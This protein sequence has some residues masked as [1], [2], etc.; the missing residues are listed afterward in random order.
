MMGFT[1]RDEPE[2]HLEPGE[3]ARH[4]RGTSPPE[5]RVRI[6]AHLAVCDRCTEEFI[7]VWRYSGKRRF[8]PALL[9]LGVAA[10][11]AVAALLL[12]PPARRPS[13]G[14]GPVVR[15]PGV[16]SV[17]LLVVVSPR[18]RDTVS[19]PVVLTWRS[20]PDMATYKV[21]V[22]GTDGDSVWALITADTSVS[23]PDS[24]RATPGLDYFWYVD[25]LMADGRA[26]TSGVH[27]FRL[28]R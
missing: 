10:A 15:G 14:A 13:D 5:E 28:H 27:Q 19:R 24:V 20:R 3:V 23:L 26:L 21:S 6:E 9:G 18:D 8:R 1:A 16:D 12:L 2:P 11:A 22:A 25:G 7:A 17:H 4:V